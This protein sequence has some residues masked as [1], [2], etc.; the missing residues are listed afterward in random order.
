LNTGDW[1]VLVTSLL[2]ETLYPTKDFLDLYH[3]RWGIETF[4]GV[5]KTRL[6]LENFTGRGTEAV[7]QDFHATIYLSG[8]ESIL[9]GTAQARLDEKKTRHPQQVNQAV[10]FH[11]IK[12]RALELLLSDLDTETL[13]QR[14][15][16]VFLT[17]P[18]LKR[19][20]RNPPRKKSSARGLLNFHKRQKKHCF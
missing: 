2:D 14:L 3:R 18:T 4:Y 9:T 20:D 5:L 15:T 16:E 19:K 1:E 10:A 8:L 6:G 17:N 13:C 12:D 7:R 11:A